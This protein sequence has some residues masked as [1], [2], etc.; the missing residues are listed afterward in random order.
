M[1]D[2][3]EILI[4]KKKNGKWDVYHHDVDNCFHDRIGRDFKDL[5]EAVEFVNKWK[6]D[7]Y[8]G[9]GEPEYGIRIIKE[10]KGHQI[11]K[12]KN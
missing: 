2:N 8:E 12:L 3:T 11:N 6:K 1:S 4:I 10:Q 5:E 7:Y 9:F